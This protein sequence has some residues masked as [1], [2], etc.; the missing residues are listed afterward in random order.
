MTQ[1]THYVKA[2]IGQDTRSRAFL[3][4][5]TADQS[6]STATGGV[7]AGHPRMADLEMVLRFVGF[8]L[9]T[10]NEYAQHA[11]FDEFLGFVTQQLDDPAGPGLEHLH[12]D[13]VRGMTNC[14]V[15]FGDHAFRKW[16]R[17]TERRNP[18]NRALF[19]SWATVLADYDAAK[20]KTGAN[21]LARL[22]RHMM[23]HDFGF[24]DS[25]SGSTGDV[26]NV[27]TRLQ[28]VHIVVKE[29]LG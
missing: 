10:P 15:V 8:R 9:F 2:F 17:D 7:V 28:K 4:K 18:I 20:V 11:S 16:P 21:K 5:L 27:R 26:R 6:F 22:A 12:A 1:T 24:I 29:V 23:T 14:H 13:F 25:I 3:K 19:E